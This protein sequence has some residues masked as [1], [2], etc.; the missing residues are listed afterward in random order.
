[1]IR[2]LSIIFA[3]LIVFNSCETE[4]SIESNELGISV[5]SENDALKDV[6]SFPIGNVWSSGRPTWGDSYGTDLGGPS[7]DF[8]SNAFG[9]L[10][11]I[12][13]KQLDLTLENEILRTQ[14]NSLTPEVALKMHN[15]A[16]SP[17]S[18]DFSEADAMMEFAEENNM[19]VHGH[20]ILFEKSVP[21]WAFEYENQN[22][23]TE[24]EWE[25]WLQ[26]Y[27]ETVVGRY[28]DRIAAWDVVNEIASDVGI[29]T[30]DYFW[31]R[32]IGPDFLEKAFKWVEEADP[33][34]KL[35]IN[36]NFQ[37]LIPNKNRVVVEIANN[38][39]ARGCKID[40]IG[41]Q[42]HIVL[43]I[44]Q[45]TYA[46]NYAAYRVAADAG[47]LVHVSELDIGTN[48]LGQTNSQSDLQHRIQR[49]SY[50]ELAR[51]YI[52]A[53]PPNQRWGITLWNIADPNAFSNLLKIFIDVRI[54]GGQQEYPLLFDN[55]YQAKPAYYGFRNGL[56]R[57]AENWLYPPLYSNERFAVTDDIYNINEQ[58]QTSQKETK[59]YI[60]TTLKQLQDRF[61]FSDSEIESIRK[62]LE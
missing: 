21:Q 28:K 31:Y 18:I 44:I 15:I 27:I 40:G 37:E 36:D 3:L 39:R 25:Y 5:S 11:T 12:K 1:M 58:I 34:A 16:I 23:W 46:R 24:E 7:A 59:Q 45:G 49:K 22:V 50:N 38:L 20:V 35:F 41:Y 29:R 54:L 53:V 48:I 51:A 32:V 19:R 4:L 8:T 9:A 13:H 61:H 52:D 17:D 43:P 60:E 26:N 33:N 42:N 30:N 56:Q 2:N 10:S 62:E 47:Y 14:F 57:V 55:D 6:A